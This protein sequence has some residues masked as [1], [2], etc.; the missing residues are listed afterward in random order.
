MIDIEKRIDELIE[1]M[2]A[3]GAKNIILTGVSYESGKTGVVVFEN[4]EY[5]YYEHQFLPNSCHG[6]GD[7][8]ASAFVGALVR[9][10]TPYEAAKIAADYTVEC[11]K[12]TAT[13]DNHWYGAA[14]EPVL[15]KLIQMLN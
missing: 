14:F 8:Y 6:T 7:I 1:K 15:G 11:I 5:K 2:R 10:K 3:L 12:F 4:N 13:L 9:G